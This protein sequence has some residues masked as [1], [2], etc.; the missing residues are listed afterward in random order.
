MTEHTGIFFE[1]FTIT[2]YHLFSGECNFGGTRAHP[3]A[4]QLQLRR[5]DINLPHTKCDAGM[6]LARGSESE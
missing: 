5:R 2:R 3:S 6:R 4:C 1:Q